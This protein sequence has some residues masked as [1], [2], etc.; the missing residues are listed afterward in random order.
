MKWAL[1]KRGEEQ[2]TEVG[3]CMPF[4]PVIGQSVWV[5]SISSRTGWTTTEVTEV[6]NDGRSFKTINSTYDLVPLVDYY[7]KKKIGEWKRTK[8]CKKDKHAL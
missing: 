7:K 8:W 1:I 2:A 5:G 4:P 3:F 6:S